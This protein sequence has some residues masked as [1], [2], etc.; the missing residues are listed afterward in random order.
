MVLINRLLFSC[1]SNPIKEFWCTGRED[2]RLLPV[3]LCKQCVRN[4]TTSNG[5]VKAFQIPS[6]PLFRCYKR[7]NSSQVNSVLKTNISRVKIDKLKVSKISQKE[8]RRLINIAKPEK[9]KL[10]GK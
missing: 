8:L 5:L 3:L 6:R 1:K 2:R 9:W 7:E 10:C 4:C